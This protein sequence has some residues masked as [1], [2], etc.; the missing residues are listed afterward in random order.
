[1]RVDAAA[2]YLYTQAL[3]AAPRAQDVAAVQ[4]TQA[5]AAV[6]ETQAPREAGARQA[7][8]TRMTIQE[9]LDWIDEQERKGE[10]SSED[11]K[12]FGLWAILQG[13][14]YN[15]ATG[16]IERA[17]KDEALDFMQRMRD[18]VAFAREHEYDDGGRYQRALEVGWAAMQRA[19]GVSMSVDVFA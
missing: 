2:S 1:M 5:T 8:F 12:E 6:E 16:Q 3:R 18:S 13:F 9:M 19:Q 17:G 10:M 14:R 4:A 11:A 7:D 15:E